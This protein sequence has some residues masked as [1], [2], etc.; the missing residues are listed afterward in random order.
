MYEDLKKARNWKEQIDVPRT[1]AVERAEKKTD[2]ESERYT[3]AAQRA[4][5][6]AFCEVV[7]RNAD[8]ITVADLLAGLCREEGTRADRV[9]SLKEHALYLRWLSGLSAL[10][11][12][13]PGGDYEEC[14]EQT[15]FNAE[16]ARAL[17]FAVKEANRDWEYWVDTD[18]LLRGLLRFPNRAHFAVLKIEVNLKLARAGSR[19]DRKEFRSAEVPMKKKTMSY[20]LRKR[21]AL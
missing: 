20:M 18:H 19:R 3:E 7:D 11:M 21:I 16:V 15:G 1:N 10:P 9:S 17:S 4:I 12:Q 5:F 2:S 6:Y 13:G 8:V 14:A